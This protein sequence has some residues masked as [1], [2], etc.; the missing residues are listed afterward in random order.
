MESYLRSAMAF[1]GIDNPEFI[2]AEGLKLG[3]EQYDAAL[4]GALK[5]AAEL[6]AA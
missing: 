1:I 2:I 5:E 3:P 6:R 4:T